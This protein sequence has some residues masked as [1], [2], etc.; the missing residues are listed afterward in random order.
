MLGS[1]LGFP[2][3]GITIYLGIKVVKYTLLMI[4]EPVP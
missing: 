1:T 3:I 2:S 4:L